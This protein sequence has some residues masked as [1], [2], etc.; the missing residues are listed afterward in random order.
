MESS[1]VVSPRSSKKDI[2]TVNDII[3]TEKN[4]FIEIEVLNQTKGCNIPYL[5]FYSLKSAIP[6]SWLSKIKNEDIIEF[7]PS[8][9]SNC[10]K[11]ISVLRNSSI[12]KSNIVQIAQNPTSQ[13]KWVEYYPYLESA[14]WKT[15]YRIPYRVVKD[16]Y[17]QSVQYKILHRI[18][19]CN[20]KLF[21]WKIKPSP[22]C[23]LC[24]QCDTLE[25][26]FYTC[27]IVKSFWDSI[28][29]WLY[30]CTGIKIDLKL[31]E[32]LL[33]I[34]QEGELF[35]CLN[36]LIITGKVY[37]KNCRQN[38]RPICFLNF[39]IYLKSKLEI[40]RIIFLKN[41]QQDIFSKRYLFLEESL[42]I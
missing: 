14:P 3:N 22:V 40:E 25:H 39:L 18:F 15:I 10:L 21:L 34:T 42:L 38:N 27:T 7:K 31:L 13:N 12:Y 37:I 17:T 9:A 6:K 41:Q 26:F 20:Y 35:Y 11:N 28:C 4:N 32:I 16:T 24:N 8:L 36:Y 23:D 29:K 30:S 5:A 1:F 33:G 2:V 19:N